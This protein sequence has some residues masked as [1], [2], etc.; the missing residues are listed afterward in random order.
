V[1]VRRA[2]LELFVTSTELHAHTLPARARL[3][4]MGNLTS[5]C[6]AGGFA[7]G[8]GIRLRPSVS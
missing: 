6:R 4:I 8:G 3:R 1:L 5:G 7:R 2:D